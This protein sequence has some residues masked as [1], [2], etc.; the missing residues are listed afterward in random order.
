[1][2]A[3][4]KDMSMR[5]ASLAL[6]AFL[7]LGLT[8][9]G[10]AASSTATGTKVTVEFTEFKFAPSN[11]DIPADQK[12]T[13]EMR[14]RGTVEHDITVDAIRL[15]AIVKPGQTATRVI[16]PFAAGTTYDVYCS[17]AGHKESGMI[18]KLTA[19]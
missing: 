19:K 3:N 10:G 11:I 5:L 14:N 2:T 17:V 13:L 7:V 12:V 15:K 16:G 6:A 1:M 9:C 8:A 18:G 4:R